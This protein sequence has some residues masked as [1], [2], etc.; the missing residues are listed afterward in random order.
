MVLIYTPKKI[1]MFDGIESE[2]E[3][4]FS[5]LN[6]LYVLV[7][8]FMVYGIN[9]KPEFDWYNY[10][11]DKMVKNEYFKSLKIW[12]AGLILILFFCLFKYLKG[13]FD[14]EYVSSILRSWLFVVIFNSAI[15]NTIKN[16][17][18]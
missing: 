8:S 12:V 1:N 10:L 16:K 18:K 3:L 5:G 17:D 2:L 14:S 7:F 15:S 11:F 6:W 9:N 4:F 13:D